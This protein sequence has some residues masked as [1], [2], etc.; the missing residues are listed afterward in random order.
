MNIYSLKQGKLFRYIMPNKHKTFNRKE[1]LSINVNSRV[2]S[3]IIVSPSSTTH[4]NRIINFKY[5]NNPLMYTMDSIEPS[6]INRFI[7]RSSN[8]FPNRKNYKSNNI[9]SNTFNNRHKN[10]HSLVNLEYE[11]NLLKNKIIE[12][13]QICSPK[14][15][16]FSIH[17]ENKKYKANNLHKNISRKV[18]KLE[19]METYEHFNRT[20]KPET[21][22]N[23]NINNYLFIN[24]RFRYNETD[25]NEFMNSPQ[26]N[27]FKLK[28]NDY[29]RNIKANNKE[30]KNEYNNENAEDENTEEIDEELSELASRIVKTNNEI[31][32]NNKN[33]INNHY[34]IYKKLNE[35]KEKN[36]LSFNKYIEGNNG[37]KIKDKYSVNT[38]N[39]IFILNNHGK[40]SDKDLEIKSPKIG[41]N[42][43]YGFSIEKLNIEINSKTNSEYYENKKVLDTID[44][45]K[46][47]NKCKNN[48]YK[49]KKNIELVP[50]EKVQINLSPKNKKLFNTIDNYK[51]NKN[52][53][54]RK[55][56]FDARILTIYYNQ[57]EK[58]PNLTIKDNKNQ[59]V[60]FV[61]LDMTQYL[62]LL[63]SNQKLKSS[64]VSKYRKIK[65]FK[66]NL[67]KN[68]SKMF[69]SNL[70]KLKMNKK[71]IT[72]DIKSKLKSK[73]ASLNKE[74]NFNE[75]D[76]NI[77]KKNDIKICLKNSRNKLGNQKINGK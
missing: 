21:P 22:V 76:S 30:I 69:S 45:L 10:N 62:N 66:F 58:V 70:K 67:G 49:I 63:T 54:K 28:I 34:K 60:E 52:D 8:I 4:P 38:V 33:K 73:L 1:N 50:S 5:Q 64:I 13:N 65:K 25:N 7:K 19:L 35:D 77:T 72:P 32:K 75:K 41:D 12:L 14:R 42:R 56:K 15:K 29:F 53:K 43:K 44:N 40:N 51:P 37:K 26:N 20:Q 59:K 11:F 47:F 46:S 55:V 17:K 48:F 68:N 24:N 74:N 2:N 23:N 9:S 6:N 61:P 27:T 57:E 18:N 39:S 71:N 31:K 16:L 3:D 36:E